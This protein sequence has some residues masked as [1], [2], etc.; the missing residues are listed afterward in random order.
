MAQRENP[1][2]GNCGARNAVCLAANSSENS[3][4]ERPP[5]ARFA[6]IPRLRRQRLVERLHRL[7]PSPL[8]HFLD[9]I[10][11]GAS[12]D[13]FHKA[14]VLPFPPRLRQIEI[15]ISAADARGPIGR[16]R[17]LRLTEHDLA[18]L[19]EAAL[20]LEARRC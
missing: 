4:I 18:R 2:A 12:T 10:E 15:R 13:N 8:F 16:T 1:A 3:R 11:R 20:R 6:A 5:Q 14:V 19:V 9:E 17:P 7:G